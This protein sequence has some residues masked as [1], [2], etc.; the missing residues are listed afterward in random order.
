MKKLCLILLVA[1]AMATAHPRG[2]VLAHYRSP[3]FWTHAP[4]ERIV[5]IWEWMPFRRFFMLS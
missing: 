1:A 2:S 4:H 5:P 3:G